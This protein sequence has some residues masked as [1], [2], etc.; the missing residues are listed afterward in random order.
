MN[1]NSKCGEERKQKRGRRGQDKL[2][3]EKKIVSQSKMK[4]WSSFG[5]NLKG[6]SNEVGVRIGLIS[7]GSV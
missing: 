4:N 2:N 5:F 3:E 7:W 6:D 1:R